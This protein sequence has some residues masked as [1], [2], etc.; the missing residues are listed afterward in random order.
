MG[1]REATS[2]AGAPRSHKVRNA[3]SPPTR[4]RIW[5]ERAVALDERAREMSGSQ[6]VGYA[7]GPRTGSDHRAPRE[8]AAPT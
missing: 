2:P 6:L 4:E 3:R 1:G 7:G 5:A 8:G